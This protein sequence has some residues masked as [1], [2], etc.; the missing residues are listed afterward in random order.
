AGLK[1]A[2]TLSQAMAPMTAAMPEMMDGFY[3]IPKFA[4]LRFG[5]WDAI[6]KEPKPKES[7][8]VSTALWHYSRATAY[9][10][11]SDTAAAAR[12]REAFEGLRKQI[13]AEAG[14]GPNNKAE[15]VLAMASELLAAR[16]G[17]NP[18]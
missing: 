15:T 17:G 11:R 7:Q 16:L 18:I 1:A 12:E 14:G 2:D 3:W 5:E 8:K 13:P 6:L 10:A 9:A 4:L